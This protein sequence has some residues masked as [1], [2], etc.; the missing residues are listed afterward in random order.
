M[1]LDWGKVITVFISCALKPGLAGIPAA[2]FAFRF[3]FLEA[4]LICS[5]GGITG[6]IVFSYLI[7]GIMKGVNILMDK[8][9]PGRNKNKKVF[10]KTN[11]FIIRA[12]RVGIIGIAAI[13]PLLLSI[14]LG[15][16]LALRFFD[17]RK[18]TIIWMSVSVVFWTVVLYLVFHFFSS[19][20]E[21]FFS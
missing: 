8:Y 14:P 19:T 11:R 7:G 10:T 1:D 4:L 12:K 15:V 6:T 2:V 9:F 13:S 21:R 5:S 18:K 3:S 20:F 16:F 17:D